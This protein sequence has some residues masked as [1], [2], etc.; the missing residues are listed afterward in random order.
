VCSSDLRTVP[1]A[2]C[3]AHGARR[4]A[5]EAR[6]ARR[7]AH[8]AVCAGDSLEA[9]LQ[10]QADARVGQEAVRYAVV[11]GYA[12]AQIDAGYEDAEYD[13]GYAAGLQV[14][15]AQAVV[16]FAHLADA[17]TRRDLEDG[18]AP[19]EAEVGADG[20]QVVDLATR[21]GVGADGTGTAHAEH[22]ARS[23]ELRSST[24]LQGI[25]VVVGV[26]GIDATSDHTDGLE[27]YVCTCRSAE[28]TQRH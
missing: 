6:R 21:L 15:R 23:D 3:T 28:Q 8:G 19:L 11:D 22:V 20:P 12:V 10:P 5:H 4:T 25:R 9:C 26:A 13:L 14:G 2:R 16:A 1:G 27:V 7:S 18:D 17:E 24:E